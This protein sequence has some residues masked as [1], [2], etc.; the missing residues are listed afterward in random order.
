MELVSK[1][2]PILRVPAEDIDFSA[3]QVNLEAFQRELVDVMMEK[4]GIGLAAPQ[5]GIGIRAFAMAPETVIFNPSIVEYGESVEKKLEGCL[6]FPGLYVK[7]P[8]NTEVAVEFYD[9]D[10]N[11]YTDRLDGVA[12][13]VFQ[14]ELDHLDGVLFVD[15]ASKLALEIANRKLR[16]KMRK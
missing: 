1:D 6:T 16:K 8:R 11:H 4:G 12:A 3:P 9:A 7:I 15:R 13:H 2:D 14:H 10:G 5:V